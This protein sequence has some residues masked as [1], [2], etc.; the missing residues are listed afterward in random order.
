MDESTA[1]VK[2]GQGLC[3][4][5]YITLAAR[6]VWREAPCKYHLP[7]LLP[8]SWSYQRRW[9]FILSAAR[10]PIHACCEWPYLHSPTLWLDPVGSF[11]QIFHSPPQGGEKA[12]LFRISMTMACNAVTGVAWH[13]ACKIPGQQSRQAKKAGSDMKILFNHLV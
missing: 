10:C 1:I 3:F 8:C 9:L 6:T 2:Q 4:S 13:T 5:T 11:V 7:H 12:R